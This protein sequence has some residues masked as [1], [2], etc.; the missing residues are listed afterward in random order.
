[1]KSGTITTN[2]AQ[3]FLHCRVC[4]EVHE[5]PRKVLRDPE[6][7]LNMLEDVIHDHRE[8]AANPTN[9]HMA[10]LEREYRKRVERELRNQADREVNHSSLRKR[11]SG[12]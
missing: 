7:V 8:C 11:C 10:K 3:Q 9:P 12:R 2:L 1:M 4:H 5:I 6:Q